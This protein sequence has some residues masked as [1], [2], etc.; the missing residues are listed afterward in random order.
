MNIYMIHDNGGRPFKVE[1]TPN[2]KTVTVYDN[3][4][5]IPLP[6]RITNVPVSTSNHRKPI[7]GSINDCSFQYIKIFPGMCADPLSL[8]NTVLIKVANNPYEEKKMVKLKHNYIYVGREI[9]SFSTAYPITDYFSE[10]GNNDVPYP[11][12]LDEKETV[13]PMHE[14]SA[15]FRLQSFNTGIRTLCN[16][17]HNYT[18]PLQIDVEELKR[19]T[20]DIYTLYYDS[21]HIT[22]YNTKS[23]QHKNGVGHKNCPFMNINQ[24]YVSPLPDE[25][26]MYTFICP[27]QDICQDR[28][29]KNEKTTQTAMDDEWDR[30]CALK[31]CEENKEENKMCLLFTNNTMQQLSKAEWKQLC[32]N[33]MDQVGVGI[34]AKKGH[35]GSI[36]EIV[37][38]SV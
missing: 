23:F 31:D 3:Y 1:V 36:Y 29:S 5:P 22:D 9:Y 2:D 17:R 25:T 18:G 24:W 35:I 34:P 6:I 21:Q 7:P 33:Y 13:Y 20:T 10:I 8:G 32:T 38:R 28:I 14:I 12:A 26:H 37:S 4:N 15:A 27:Y 11:F 19:G 30:L 16:L